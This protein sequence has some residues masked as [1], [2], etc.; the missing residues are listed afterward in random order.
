[1]AKRLIVRTWHQK[2]LLRMNALNL[3]QRELSSML[4]YSESYISKVLRGDTRS[5]SKAKSMIDATLDELE[6]TAIS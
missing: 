6:R 5:A 4:H 1:M 2:T 3:S